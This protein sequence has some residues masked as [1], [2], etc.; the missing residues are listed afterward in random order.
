MREKILIFTATYNER[1]NIKIFIDTFLKLNLKTDLLIIDDNSPDK[2][3]KII[4]KYQKKYKNIKLII[5]KKK[6]GLNTAHQLAFNIAQKKKYKFLITLDADLTHD[7]SNIPKFV[8]KIKNYSFVI[9]SRYMKN[10]K[11]DITGWRFLLS[12]VGNKFIKYIFNIKI[13]EFTS[14]YR[15]YNLM[16][17][18]KLDLCKIKSN[19]YS[20]FMEVVYII[21]KNNY[22]MLEFPIYAKQRAVGVSKIPKIEIIRTAYNIFRLK[23]NDLIN[24]FKLNLKI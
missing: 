23:F 5:R 3:Y 6:E 11:T 4:E 2:T 7:L 15:A 8:K 13:N 14:S 22:S 9:G 20:F 21:N 24:F 19:G 10:G 16:K 1:D 18:K 12:F 17:L